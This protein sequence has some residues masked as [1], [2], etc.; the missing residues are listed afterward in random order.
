MVRGVLRAVRRGIA[1][2]CLLGVCGVVG[3]TGCKSPLDASLS[4]C[5]GAKHQE[6]PM[7]PIQHRNP[8]HHVRNDVSMRL[9]ARVEPGCG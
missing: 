5:Q 8:N 4:E 1:L 3:A 2:G 7:Q 6:S 9:K